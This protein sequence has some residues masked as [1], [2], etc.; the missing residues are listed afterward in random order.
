MSSPVSDNTGGLAVFP[1]FIWH[2]TC[3][4]RYLGWTAPGWIG[5][6]L[7][8][9]GGADH[10]SRMSCFGWASWCLLD[11]ASTGVKLQEIARMETKIK[12]SWP[13]CEARSEALR[14]ITKSK[15]GLWL[16]MLRSFCFFVPDVQWYGGTT[17]QKHAR[18]HWRC[19]CSNDA[20]TAH[21]IS[22]A[23]IRSHAAIFALS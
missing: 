18:G 9:Y 7:K 8:P 6:K 10:L 13:F 4:H 16:N 3:V 22:V 20:G 1:V 19:C 21:P 2:H 12:K 17:L 15:K 23:S 14:L 5:P 11:M